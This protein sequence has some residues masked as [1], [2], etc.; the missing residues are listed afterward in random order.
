[1]D[2]EGDVIDGIIINTSG[3]SSYQIPMTEGPVKELRMRLPKDTD[4]GA[5][6]MTAFAR[7]T[8]SV[9]KILFLFRKMKKNLEILVQ[10]L[11]SSHIICIII[12]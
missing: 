4:R 11:E 1:M 12:I 2:I 7:T 9:N 8:Y 5:K 10:E 3:C 6:D